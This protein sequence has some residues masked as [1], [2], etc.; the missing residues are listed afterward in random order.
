MKPLKVKNNKPL[1]QFWT[2]LATINV[3]ALIYPVQLLHR[4]ESGD[5]RLLASLA[6]MVVPFLL[7]VADAISVVIAEVIVST[8]N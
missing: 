8:R 7:M 3:L 4:A 6:L 2:V 1:K 5:E